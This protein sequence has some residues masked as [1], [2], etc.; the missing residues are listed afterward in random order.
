M[1]AWRDATNFRVLIAAE[2][3]ITSRISRQQIERA[4]DLKRQLRNVDKIFVRVFGSS[5]RVRA[6][7]PASKA[8]KKQ[9]TMA[10][11]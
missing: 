2:P 9:T 4:F 11:E 1:Q 7:G 3:E 8:Q 5:R 10:K 6:E